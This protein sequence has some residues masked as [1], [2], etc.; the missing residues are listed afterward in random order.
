MNI[1]P[2][3]TEMDYQA[4]LAEIEKYFDAKPDTP[5][6]DKL[7]V[8]VT[9]VEAYE[10]KHHAIDLPDPIDAI[11]YVMESKGLTRKDLELCIGSRARISEILSRKRKLTLP[12]IRK[13]YK[14][15]HIPAR[16]LIR[17]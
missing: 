7:D 13:L 14:Q 5:K 4:S 9:L 6:G 3:K 11:K 2:I 12:M 15:F 17:A 16:V 8:L 1:K 10:E